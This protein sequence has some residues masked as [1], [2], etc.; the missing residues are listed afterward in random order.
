MYYTDHNLKVFWGVIL[1]GI[2]LL[3]IVSFV[4]SVL[5]SRGTTYN[6]FGVLLS[7]LTVGLVIHL[8][9]FVQI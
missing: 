3:L 1:A 7:F 5:A 8:T 6:W 2:L 4:R 9:F